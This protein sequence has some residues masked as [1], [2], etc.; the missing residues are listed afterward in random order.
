MELPGEFVVGSAED[1]P[2]P[3]DAFDAVCSMGV[4]HHTPD[5]AG[6]VAE[7][8]RVLKPGG[9]LIVMFYHRNSAVYRRLQL[10]S[11]LGRRPLQ[12]LVNEVD[13]VGNPKGDVYSRAELRALLA[14]FSDVECSVGLLQGLPIRGHRFPPQAAL[15][16]F[17]SRW[18]WFLYAK[19]RK[20]ETAR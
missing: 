19:A 18:G 1:L 3:S 4:L 2:F 15:R 7:V 14:G 9:R 5:T 16:P 8:K 6:A 20:P 17:A 13:G 10:R 12:E 11:R